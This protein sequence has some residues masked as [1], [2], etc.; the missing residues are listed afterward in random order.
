VSLLAT[1]L[2]TFGTPFTQSAQAGDRF[3]GTVSDLC[4]VTLYMSGIVPL[5]CT[6]LTY[7]QVE[8]AFAPDG[9]KGLRHKRPVDLTTS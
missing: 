5:A 8:M 7:V 4:N 3:S 6:A 9:D 1:L 2:L